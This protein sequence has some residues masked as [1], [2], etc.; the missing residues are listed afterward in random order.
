MFIDIVVCGS[1]CVWEKGSKRTERS[2][3]SKSSRTSLRRDSA[4]RID[5]TTLVSCQLAAFGLFVLA[6]TNGHSTARATKRAKGLSNSAAN[7]GLQLSLVPVAGRS[8]RR[9]T[10]VKTAREQDGSRWSEETRQRHRS[11]PSPDLLRTSLL[12]R[13]D[14]FASS[15]Q[16]R[17]GNNKL[18]RV[19]NDALTRPRTRASWRERS[20]AVS[21]PCGRSRE[22]GRGHPGRC[23]RG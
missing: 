7:K 10:P 2:G 3:S 12:R 13:S 15:L 21:R 11:P 19:Q 23:W 1:K 16:Q 18:K 5:P 17:E 14:R 6:S 22:V 4:T 20:L 8:L 9:A